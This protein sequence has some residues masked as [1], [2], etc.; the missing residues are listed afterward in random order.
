MHAFSAVPDICADKDAAV[1]TIATLL[2]RPA[3]IWVCLGLYVSS[4]AL[5][6]HV[7]PTP[8]AVALGLL[9]A[10]LMLR[11]LRA[12]SDEAIVRIY[13]LFPIVNT[14]I[15]SLLFAV[16]FFSHHAA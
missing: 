5:S 1:P 8:V 10:A 15:G 4:A 3:T 7:L 6:A 12:R 14:V 13:R 16:V 11:A 2:G 9:Y